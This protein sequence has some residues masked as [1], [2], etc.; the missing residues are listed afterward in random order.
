MGTVPNALKGISSMATRQL[1]AELVANWHAQGGEP[2][3]IES[4][5]GVDAAQRVLNG[6]AFD[7]V[8]LASDAITKLEAAGRV[9]PGSRVDLVRSS[10]A[11]AVSAG[12]AAPDISSEEAVRAAVLVAQGIGYST[13]PS[14]VALQALFARWGIT[15][16]I[17]PRLVQARPGVPVASLVASGEVALGFQQLSEL[18]HVPGIAIVGTLPQTIAIDTV[19]SAGVAAASARADAARRLLAF[20]AAPGAAT[21]KRRQ[22]MEPV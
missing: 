15:G 10:T 21:A 22:G 2:V 8:I 14:G 20:L 3:D 12:A 11:V 17:R 1:L 18:L 13:G 19:F 7:V 5:G 16:Q 4:V 6:E 9:L